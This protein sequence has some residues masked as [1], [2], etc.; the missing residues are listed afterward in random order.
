MQEL[1]KSREHGDSNEDWIKDKKGNRCKYATARNQEVKKISI[2][3]ISLIDC[4]A[5]NKATAF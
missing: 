3:I 5:A 2:A 4:A 1:F